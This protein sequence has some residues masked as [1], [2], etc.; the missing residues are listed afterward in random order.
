MSEQLN[1]V[2]IGVPIQSMCDSYFAYDLARLT[3]FS[4]VAIPNT[5]LILLFEQGTYLFQQRQNIAEVFMQTDATHLLWLDSDMRFPKESLQALLRHDLPIV[6]TNYTKR[7]PPHIPVA[8]KDGQP[9]F[10]FE[11]S[12]PLE[13]AHH[14]GLGLTLMKREVFAKLGDAEPY[15]PIRYDDDESQY[16]GE[17]VAFFRKARLAGFKVMI[18]QDLS[19]YVIHR[20]NMDYNYMHALDTREHMMRTAEGLEENKEE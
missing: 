2:L 14:T 13:E 20:G 15:F 16:V 9:F 8:K 17:D 5:Q 18:D 12:E 7:L 1:K 4:G 19:K 6:G 10:T 11:D 3:A